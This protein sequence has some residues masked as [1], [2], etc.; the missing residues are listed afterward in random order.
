MRQLL[1][2]SGLIEKYLPESDKAVFHK[3]YLDVL[4]VEDAVDM[5]R[6]LLS[7]L[8]ERLRNT[9][10]R[11]GIFIL[12]ADKIF[13]ER[14]S[15]LLS[16]LNTLATENEHISLLFFLETDIL[17][18]RYSE[19]RDTKQT[20]FYLQNIIY[21]SLYSERDIEKFID[22]LEAKFD[23]VVSGRLRK[24]IKK[25]CGGH[26]WLVKEAVRYLR[27]HPGA[28]WVDISNSP[29]LRFKVKTI[30]KS[31][32]EN[33]RSV[34]QEV[35]TGGKGI[36]GG[37]KDSFD[38]LRRVG[39]LTRRGKMIKVGIELL[40]RLIL[41]LANNK[42]RLYCSKGAVY[43]NGVKLS[44]VFSEQ[45]FTGLKLLVD[46]PGKVVG[47]D[48]LAQAIW[49]DQA[50][51]KYSEWAIYKLISRLRAKLVDLGLPAKSIKTL[52]NRGFLLSAALVEK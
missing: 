29:A 3:I 23:L 38:F 22:Y 43:L 11:V 20:P 15:S 49:K 52:R 21:Q 30:W 31:L 48:Q 28:D 25:Q 33:E 41:E 42:N 32:S 6:V 47:K 36:K 13:T 7:S 17:H 39:L 26:L 51:E 18:D 8:Y 27:K 50:V 44:K 9:S 34:L 46:N 16:Y 5:E 2:S 40:E 10:R 1:S 37:D 4:G 24:R 14:L 12:D 19:L 35:V 45:E